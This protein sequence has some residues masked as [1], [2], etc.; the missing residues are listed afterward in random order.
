MSC[1]AF[2]LVVSCVLTVGC[3]GCSTQERTDWRPAD[4]TGTGQ[5]L[6][7][8]PNRASLLG[9]ALQDLALSGDA[10]CSEGQARV[11]SE[12][13]FFALIASVDPGSNAVAVDPIEY[14]T[15]A[16]AAAAAARDG[17]RLDEDEG[18]YVR[19]RDAARLELSFA[20]DAVVVLWYPPETV[21]SFGRPSAAALGALTP[22]EF[23]A[24]YVRDEQRRA[25][26]ASAGA[27]LVVQGGR[28]TTLIENPTP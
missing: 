22:E 5:A 7:A 17:R 20:E 1:V 16:G 12:G 21:P 14:Y 19:N 8:R 6:E 18:V 9:R 13:S 28:I 11:C 10:A 25:S 23:A 4:G 15:G 2:M 27:R 24:E 3:V 26:L